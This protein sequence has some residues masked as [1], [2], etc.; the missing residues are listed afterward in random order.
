MT[1]PVHIF[2]IRH[3]G[4]GSARSLK[5]ALHE[6]QPDLVLVEGPPD[7]ADVL[8]H[9]AREEMRPPVALLLH[10]RDEPRRA[11]YY[12]FA[13]FSPEWQ[14]LRY[15]HEC[16]VPVRFMDL[17]QAHQ[18]ALDIRRE[19]ELL[20]LFEAERQRLA[21]PAREEEHAGSR[22]AECA[23]D[24]PSLTAAPLPGTGETPSASE[25]GAG[26]K[27][28]TGGTASQEESEEG[29]LPLDEAGDARPAPDDG[30]GEQESESAV[31]GIPLRRDPLLWLAHA[32]G[33]SDG[34]RWWDHIVESRLDGTGLFA[35]ILEAMT[36]LRAEAPEHEDP[37]EATREAAREAWMRRTIRTA[38]KEGFQRIAVVC[39]AWHGPALVDLPPAR[40]DDALLKGLPSVP[41]RATWIPWTHGRLS[42]DSGYGAG[43]ESPGWY[44]HLWEHS[45][46]AQIRWLT[47]VAQ[48]LREEGLETSSAHVIEA[49]RLADSLAAVRERPRPGLP[50]LNEAVQAVY[51]F[52]S[53]LPMALIHERLIVGE[54]LGEVPVD[55]P[56]VPLQADLLREQKRLRLAREE[57]HRDLDLDLRRETDAERSR[58]L[59]RLRLLGVPWGQVRDQG[60]RQ[61]GTFHENWRLQWQ[62]EMDVALIEAGIW[63]NTIAEAA[64]AR[65]ADLARRTEILPP[66]TEL[67]DDV[68]LADLPDAVSALMTRL[69]E[70]ATMSADLGH[71]ME[72]LPPLAAVQR[73]GNVRR[74]DATAVG[75]I[76]HGLTT[77]I[78]VGLP[79]AC[80]SLNDDAAGEMYPRLL[81]VHAALMTLNDEEQ[82]NA[83]SQT[84]HRL[85]DQIGGH[86]LISGRSCRL[87]LDSRR[88]E[89][90]EA[91]RRL[92][93]ALS[94]ATEP[95]AAA[96]WV[97]G[98]LRDSGSLL[99]HDPVLWGVVDAWVT[100]LAPDVFT[101][102]VPLLR[103]TFSTFTAPERRNLGQ[104]VR[105]G[106]SRTGADGV[107]KSD[108]HPERAARPL[109][110][111]ALLLGLSGKGVQDA[112]GGAQGER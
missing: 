111:L 71:L 85:A 106:R 6:L 52:G 60:A 29:S 87:L 13:A 14:A 28:C 16:S 35:G 86:G 50:E 41:I 75:Q 107:P 89:P 20:A 53:E 32:A 105:Q 94:T 47:R 49:V 23:G 3:H 95:A 97:E 30:S 12:P 43:I 18:M 21:E 34:E 76:V 38:L 57:A 39:G 108:L 77:R 93:L 44:S 68:L 55:V 1:Q 11:V 112:G 92:G 2:G 48:L 64:A 79:S 42:R 26:R 72:V 88:I 45:E 58:L 74:T 110:T 96:A 19:Q 69:Q 31:P 83:W 80:S 37:D 90:A 65:T 40:Q 82:L 4:P 59:H 46:Q 99:L 54:G 104:V 103:R 67:L 5:R 51:C 100:G 10:H 22:D 24:P 25:S 109:P 78:C 101:Q 17:P 66:L 8:V 9:V 98:L 56:V 7:A 15:S 61:K 73:Y 81:G 36:A 70:L 27:R 63:G 33:Y 84:L 91:A 62:P 102:L